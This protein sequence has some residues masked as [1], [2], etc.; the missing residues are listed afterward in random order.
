MAVSKQEISLKEMQT[1]AHINKSFF[2]LVHQNAE[3]SLSEILL[4]PNVLTKRNCVK[5]EF[6][7][8]KIKGKI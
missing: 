8:L 7:S 4:K 6:T 2:K 5:D 3:V 1:C